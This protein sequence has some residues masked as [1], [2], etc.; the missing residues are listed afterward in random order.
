M[1]T[2][3][4]G[5]LFAAN[6]SWKIFMQATPHKGVFSEGFHTTTSPHTNA[7]IAFHD[8]TATGKLNAEIT[9]TIPSGCHCSYMRCIFL[10]ECMV[11]PYNC[12][13]SPTAKSHMSIISCTSPQPSWRL[14]PISYETSLPSASLLRRKASPYC[15]TISPRLGAGINLHVSNVFEA[16]RM[17]FSYSFGVV[18]LT[19]PIRLPST[20]DGEG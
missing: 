19:A 17:T 3:P 2:I 1:L 12:R 4:S 10:S 9:P 6:T 7:I 20:G 18:V 11:S 16:V 8:Q 5:K 14:F 13:E 15:R